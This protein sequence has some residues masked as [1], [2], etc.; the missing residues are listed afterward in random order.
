MK[1][2]SIGLF[3]TFLGLLIFSACKEYEFMDWKIA[4]ERYFSSLEDSLKYYAS[5]KY[6][7]LP[8]SVKVFNPP[9]QRDSDKSTGIY[10]YYKLTYGGNPSGRQPNPTSQV[11]VNYSGKFYDGYN[12]DSGKNMVVSLSNVVTAWRDV[13]TKMKTGA[14]LKLFVPSKLGYDTISTNSKIPA[15]STL[16]FDIELLDSQK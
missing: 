2:I 16:I 6:T 1:R 10:Y 9:I 12:F 14:K 8:D 5:A 4:N 15:H 3:I 7:S 13:L 11:L